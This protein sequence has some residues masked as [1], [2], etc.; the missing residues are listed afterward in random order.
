MAAIGS[1]SDLLLDIFHEWITVLYDNVIECDVC[2][3]MFWCSLILFVIFS[4]AYFILVKTIFGEY[5]TIFNI[6]VGL[7]IFQ[8]IN[9]S[10]S[11]VSSVDDH[12][13]SLM[14]N[15]RSS[16]NTNNIDDEFAHEFSYDTNSKPSRFRKRGRTYQPRKRSGIVK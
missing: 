4:V 8:R 12:H 1:N 5:S 6:L 3:T 10:K 2:K 7:L 15:T 16:G 11:S 14:R 13:L 9:T